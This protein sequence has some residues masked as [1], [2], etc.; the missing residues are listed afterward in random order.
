MRIIGVVTVARSDYGIYLPVLHRIQNDPDLRLQLYV[1]GM[2]L[3]PEFG[4]TVRQIENDGFNIAARVEMLL[5]S[6]S[7]EGIAK[8]T[9]L[10]ILGFAQALATTPCDILLVLGD[11]FEMLAAVIAAL[12]FNIPIAHLHGGELTEG[13]IDDAIRHAITKISHLHFVATQQYARR[14]IQMGEEPWRVTVSGA[15][16]LDNLH[17]LAILSR[18][19]LATKYG[20]DL[21]P[22]FLLLTYHPVTR[23][24]DQTEAHVN[25]L[26]NVLD[27]IDAR[28]V[29][30]YPNADTGGRIIIEKLRQFVQS[31]PHAF[32]AVNLGTQTYFSMMHHAAA[33]VGNSSSGVLEAA[34]FKLPV[35]NIGNRQEGRL[36]S[37]NVID[38]NC[39]EADITEGLRRVL[40]PGFRASLT[41]LSNPYG[42]GQ[43]AERI[44]TRLK[45]VE[46]G[47]KL[48]IKHFED[49]L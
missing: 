39:T 18:E 16:A 32:L 44:V 38:V 9:G 4:M 22:P 41:N 14:I 30:T 19:E 45:T 15:P 49:A 28:L 26:L 48:L 27:N 36:R 34:S 47:R 12:P 29:F 6:D 25:A 11:R 3:S 43:A 46:T 8:A 17:R 5:S 21:R 24:Y 40:S 31:R 13:A 33:M 7:P 10:G 2:H 37:R 20:C 35:L 1:G 42:D 23:E